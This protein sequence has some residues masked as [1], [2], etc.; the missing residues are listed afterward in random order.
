MATQISSP[1]LPEAI[2]TPVASLAIPRLDSVD[3]LC[4]I[5]M[6]AMALDHTRDFLT[7]LRFP[8]FY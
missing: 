2:L 3:L 6:V 1:V 4:G 8:G 5:I 7:H